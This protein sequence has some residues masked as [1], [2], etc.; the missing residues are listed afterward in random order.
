MNPET[1]NE[2]LVRHKRP[3][4][5]VGGS[6]EIGQAIARKLLLDGFPTVATYYSSGGKAADLQIFCTDDGNSVQCTPLNVTDHEAVNAFF[7]D[8]CKNKGVPY[9]L[10]YLA[11]TA[12]NA[13]LGKMSNALWQQALDTHLT[14]CFSCVREAS[15]G[16]IR[17]RTGRII[18][19]TSDAALMGAP[20]RANYCA[21]K[22]GI[23]GLIKSCA[24]E[25]APFGV[26][27]NAVS[28]GMIATPRIAAWPDDTRKRLIQSIPMKRFGTPEDI[29]SL[30]SFLCSEGAGY[31]TGQ[32][33]QVDGG[34]RM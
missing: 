10:I 7:E 20:M 31:I 33:F 14:G 9:S 23:I 21:A 17:Q 1:I 22:A 4:I 16:M 29:A 30:V 15:K 32:V 28:P 8:I 11:G 24:L 3:A 12:E 2:S 27:A 25:L 34:L 6:S 5:V 13:Y 18:A 19:I 26:T